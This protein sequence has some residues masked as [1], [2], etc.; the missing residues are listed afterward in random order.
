[1]QP[2]LFY[3][4]ASQTAPDRT[5]RTPSGKSFVDLPSGHRRQRLRKVAAIAVGV[6]WL[7]LVAAL[8]PATAKIFLRWQPGD[9]AAILAG[10]QQGKTLYESPARMNGAHGHA[11][12][13]HYEIDFNELRADM[14]A[15]K[16][17]GTLDTSDTLWRIGARHILGTPTAN[18]NGKRTLIFALNGQAGVLVVRFQPSDRRANPTANRLPSGMPVYA[19]AAIQWSM[20]LDRSRLTMY[21]AT[22]NAHTA[23][24]AASFD[25]SLRHDG[26][27]DAIG[28]PANTAVKPVTD[29]VY[30]KNGA[31]L[32]FGARPA[33]GPG[34][35][36]THLTVVQKQR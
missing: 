22:V 15:H 28:T 8:W 3:R 21:S 23:T 25:S 26:W 31:I 32:I 6:V 36:A 1:M 35:A 30:L 2:N 10:E 13:A 5:S 33:R 16:K 20:E 12:V 24:V 9:T 27:Q 18:P 14:I 7:L 11:R 4:D 29:G 17:A 34:G 19:G